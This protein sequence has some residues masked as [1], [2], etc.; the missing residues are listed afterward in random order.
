LKPKIEKILLC[1]FAT[2]ACYLASSIPA[3]AE[4]YI[5]VYSGQANTMDSDL[6]IVQPTLMTD[7]TFSDLSYDDRSFTGTFYYGFKLGYSPPSIPF[8]AFELEFFHFKIHADPSEVVSTNGTLSGGGSISTMQP[9]GNIVQKF[10]IS[11]GVNFV[12]FN[13][14]GRHGFV[15]KKR[16][17]NGQIQVYTGVGLGIEISHGDSVVD[18]VASKGPYQIDDDPAVQF[19]A[20]LRLFPLD[21]KWDWGNPILFTEYKYT[22]AHPDVDI[23]QG[24][25]SVA[26][27]TNHFIF[28]LGWHF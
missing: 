2:L 7:L 16:F 27:N 28:G 9:L 3:M 23:D 14:V 12:T 25:A 4:P 18:G 19:F 15:K 5:Y 26:I 17:P 10:E 22:M 11:D 20:G 24:T 21:L 6:K 1:T 13:I 8:L